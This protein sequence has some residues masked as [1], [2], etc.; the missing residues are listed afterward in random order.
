MRRGGRA[1]APR[2]A[3][4]ARGAEIRDRGWLVVGGALE[5]KRGEIARRVNRRA[6]EGERVG[7]F[8]PL[9]LRKRPSGVL[10]TGWLVASRLRCAPWLHACGP[11]G[12]SDVQ[13]EMATERRSKDAAARGSFTRG[14]GR[15]HALPRGRSPLPR[16]VTPATSGPSPPPWAARWAFRDRAMGVRGC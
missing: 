1:R 16:A 6:C 8:G 3:A 5:G 15:R 12:R 13:R 2:Q 9:Q 4:G 14:D 11:L 10:S 7:A